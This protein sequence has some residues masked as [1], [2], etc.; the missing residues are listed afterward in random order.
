MERK[1]VYITMDFW[2]GFIKSRPDFTPFPEEN[3][4]CKGKIWYDLY[5]FIRRSNLFFDCSKTEYQN[6]ADTDE[7]YKMLWKKSTGGEC[8]LEFNAD[9]KNCLESGKFNDMLLSAVYLTD[10]SYDKLAADMGVLNIP[11]ENYADFGE[12]FADNGIA[13]N[14]KG[15]WKQVFRGCI[16]QTCNALLI[17]DNY[18]FRND[19][20][21]QNLIE[22]LDCLIPNKLKT[23]FHLTIVSSRQRYPFTKAEEDE[24]RAKR[25]LIKKE[26]NRIRPHIKSVQIEVLFVSDEFHDRSIVSNYIWIGTGIGFGLFKNGKSNKPTT[27]QI[28]YPYF[29]DSVKWVEKAY[30]DVIKNAGKAISNNGKVSR[31]RLFNEKIV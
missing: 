2:D 1:N 30:G 12:L 6:K 9:I 15:N 4:I 11:L 23:E 16:K 14:K 28:I 22:L 31:N 29:C 8:G 20:K 27:F 25:N 7:Y 19:S 18:I 5:L 26:L 21:L 3:I 17:I 24:E 10:T 13:I